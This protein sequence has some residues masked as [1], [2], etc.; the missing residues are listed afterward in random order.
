[1]REIEIGNN[2][3]ALTDCKC[4]HPAYAH[5]VIGLNTYGFEYGPCT[6]CHCL[7]YNE[8]DQEVADD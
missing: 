3:T 6:R 1:M 5:K 2:D 7:R 8:P 4:G